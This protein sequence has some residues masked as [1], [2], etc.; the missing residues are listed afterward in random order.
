MTNLLSLRA[1]RT[2]VCL[3]CA[4]LFTVLAM[5]Q[6]PQSALPPDLDDFTERSIVTER[7]TLPWQPVR[8]ADILWEK[9]IWRIVDVREKLNLPFAAPES[10]LFKVLAEAVENGDLTAYSTDNDK[11]TKP[12][13][14]DAVLSKLY[15][16][17]TISIIN[18]ETGLEEIKVV[19]NQINWEDV[20]RFRL[21]EA[22]FFDANT[23]RMQVRI[24]GIA[25]LIEVTNEHGDFEYEV[26]LFW[27]H[28]PSARGYL[29]QHKAITQG[30][31]L[32]ATTTW[33]DILETRRFA[34]IVT[35][36]NN[37]QD[38]RLMDIYSGPE[39]VLQ[40]KKIDDALFNLEHDMWS[41]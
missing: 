39:L 21:K 25:P 28:Y 11:F 33:E 12:M 7:R 2:S 27:I 22:W 8:E 20:K 23:G 34:S 3:G 15:H 40:G 19:E 16:R 38:N 37:V 14:N 30:G 41:W 1:F 29:A 31:N 35:K 17:D 26:P 4:M 6:T 9:R 5:A 10:P 13:S 32:A 36:Q 18:M 24:L